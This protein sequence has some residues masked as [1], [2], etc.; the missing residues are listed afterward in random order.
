MDKEMKDRIVYEIAVTSIGTVLFLAIWWVAEMPEWKR[1]AIL[2]RLKSS[3]MI[4]DGLT[5]LERSEIRSFMQEISRW[6]HARM[7]ARKGKQA[8]N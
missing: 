6:E 5:A 3:P 1:K 8:G 7:A 4:S 2:L